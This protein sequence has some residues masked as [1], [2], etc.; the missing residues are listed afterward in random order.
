MAVKH[1]WRHVDNGTRGP[2]VAICR[3]CDV[4][5]ETVSRQEY[6]FRYADGRI[7]RVVKSAGIPMCRAERV[8]ALRR[9]RRWE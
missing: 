2:E 8:R 6:R 9:W 4:R 3:R 7:E 5:R 1:W